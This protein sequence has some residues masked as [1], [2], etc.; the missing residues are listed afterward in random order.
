M[1]TI[2]NKHR[3]GLA[4]QLC[5]GLHD[6]DAATLRDYYY[7]MLLIRRFAERTEELSTTTS[8]G[9]VCHRNRGD[10]ATIVGLLAALRPEDY[11]FTNHREGG[12][13]VARGVAPVQVMPTMSGARPNVSDGQR[14]SMQLFD[15]AT[16]FMD[17]YASVG[18]GLSLAVVSA[19]CRCAVNSIVS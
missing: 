4:A 9:G 15:P 18:A 11:I 1:N 12:Y 13:S 6:E 5:S 7:R 2:T 19:W 3:H 14:S 16:Y 8:T 10:E 17:D